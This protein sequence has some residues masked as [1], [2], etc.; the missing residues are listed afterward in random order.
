MYNAGIPSVRNI[1]TLRRSSSTQSFTSKPW[2]RMSPYRLLLEQPRRAVVVVA[3][4]DQEVPAQLVAGQPANSEFS[5]PGRAGGEEHY[6]QLTRQ[7]A[8]QSGDL[9]DEGVVT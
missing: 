4:H 8:E 2:A 1:S 3:P 9:V 5:R 6:R 7:Q